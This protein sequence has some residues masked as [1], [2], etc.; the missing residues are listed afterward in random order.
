MLDWDRVRIFHAVAGAGSFTKAAD[1]LGLSQSAISRQIGAL[2]EDL[3]VSL[4]HRHA[5]GLLLTEHGE[6]LLETAT[7]VARRMA[8]MQTVLGEVRNTASGHLRVNTTVGIGTVWLVSH[9][10]EFRELYPEISITLVAS[11]SD[12]DLSMREADVAIRLQ[13]PTQSDLIQ[14]KLMTAHTHIYGSK[15]YVAKHGSPANVDELSKHELIAYGDDWQPPVSGLNWIL[16]A[17]MDLAESERRT[18]T[19][20]I[21]NVFGMLRATECGLGLASLPD[22][23]CAQSPQLQRVLSDIEG[24]GFTAYFVYPEE[25][26]SSRRVSAFRDFLLEKVAAQP[27]W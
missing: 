12:L 24:P 6:I 3:G 2:E 14:R 17:G 15:A 8:S 13:Q 20:K 19:L 18:P 23:L 25:L 21:N 22:Y 10:A 7:A 4:F 9:L 5:R 11:D 16:E 26:R 1:R 27:V